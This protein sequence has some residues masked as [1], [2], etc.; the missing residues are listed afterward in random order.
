MAFSGIRLLLLFSVYLV[1]VVRLVELIVH[2]RANNEGV[3]KYVLI[4][5]M[6]D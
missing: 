6:N 5:E 2:K 3:S 4:N 1:N